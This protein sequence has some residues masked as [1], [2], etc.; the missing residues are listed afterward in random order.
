MALSL[1]DITIPVFISSLEQTSHF[2][3]KAKSWAEEN[4]FPLSKFVE[5]RLA[6]DMHPLPFQIQE[7]T[8]IARDL[9]VDIG[10]TELVP[11]ARDE[12]T[13]EELQATVTK[14]IAILQ[15]V[16]TDCMDGKLDTTIKLHVDNQDLF[17]TGKVY[18]LKYAVPDFFFHVTTAYDILRNLG[19]PVGKFDY[20][21]DIWKLQTNPI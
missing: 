2:L 13:F 18:A 8:N 9:A 20:L 6:P 3:A 14:T 16:P 10:K 21:G 4:G 19:A 1:Y 7:M 17:F 5:G 11:F 12:K 15:K